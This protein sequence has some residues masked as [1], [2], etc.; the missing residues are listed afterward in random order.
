[1]TLLQTINNDLYRLKGNVGIRTL[2]KTFFFNPLFRKLVYYRFLQK[3]RCTLLA[4]FLY[5]FVS[6]KVG[7]EMAP[8]VKL[9]YGALFIHPYAITI[10]SKAI[11]GNNF[12]MLKGATIGNS[13]TGRVGAPVI[14]DNVYVSLNS[15]IIGGIKIGNNVLIAP[16]T[17]V[18]FDVPDDCVVLGSPGV[19]HKKTNASKPYTVNSIENMKS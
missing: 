10:N 16:N 19:I 12:T 4:R 1:M 13:K 6:S 17:F 5:H 7:V 14:G 9:G 8:S 15:S 11:I 18:N 3:D 2:I